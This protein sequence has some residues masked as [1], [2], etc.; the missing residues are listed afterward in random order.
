MMKFDVV[1]IGGGAAGIV[2]AISA[3][4]K[5]NSV[6]ICDRMPKLGKKIL[7]SGN[8]RC[9][10]LNENFSESF[11][12]QDSRNLVKSVFA[13]FGKSRVLDFFKELGLETYSEE[14]RILPRS[15]Q[16]MSV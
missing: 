3:R 4:R 16:P 10:L 1:V 5:G 7:A 14:G 2:A 9:N 13:N 11:F 6:V 12:N 15:R 8:G